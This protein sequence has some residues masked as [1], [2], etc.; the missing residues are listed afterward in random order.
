MHIIDH[1][2]FIVKFSF[3]FILSMLTL[4]VQNFNAASIIEIQPPIPTITTANTWDEILKILVSTAI[5]LIVLF[6]SKWIDK[7]FDEKGKKE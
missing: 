5:T 3:Y 6:A 2:F 4:S 1:L 7:Y